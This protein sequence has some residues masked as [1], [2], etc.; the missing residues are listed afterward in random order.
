MVITEV[1]ELSKSRSKVYLDGEFAFVLYK[2]E[3]RT[4]HIKEGNTLSQED[5]I[6]IMEI[7]LTKRAKLRAMN[8]L[9]ARPYTEFQLR[10]KLQDGFYPEEIIDCAINYVKSYHYI[11]DEQYARQYIA[12]KLPTASKKKIEMDLYQKGISKEC[13]KQVFE[14]LD[15]EETKEQELVL[16]QKLLE[17]KR[18][19]AGETDAKETARIFGFLMRKGFKSE[20]IRQAMKTWE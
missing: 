10:K 13:M 6:E 15:G 9:T 5:Y 2:G 1:I 12:Y 8:L 4:F 3:L 16:I 19:V 20:D 7:I 14:E 18:Y 11:D 17:K